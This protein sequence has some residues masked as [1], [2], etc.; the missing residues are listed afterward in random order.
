MSRWAREQNDPAT[1]LDSLLRRATI[2]TTANTFHDSE[3]GRRLL[4]EAQA[5]AHSVGDAAAE[6]RILWNLLLATS[7]SDD[8]PAVGRD[9]GERA[10]AIA[11]AGDHKE[12]TAFILFDLWYAYG[13]LG[14]WNRAI[15]PLLEARELWREL[16]NLPL[17]A[18]THTRLH[19]SALFLGDYE[20]SL[21]YAQEANR[22]SRLSNNLESQAISLSAV[23][24]IYLDRGELQR[25]LNLMREALA[26]GEQA[27]VVTALGGT[28]A[29][30]GWAYGWLGDPARGIALA[31]AAD[32]WIAA[33]IPNVRG[34]ALGP[35]ARLL[36]RTNELER[37]GAIL[38]E[39]GSYRAQMRRLGF[40]V[41]IWVTAGLA[42][43]ELA[44]ARNRP[45]EA[46]AVAE[47]LR[48][49][50]QQRRLRF[51]LPDVVLLQAEALL[52]LGRTEQ[53]G[54]TLRTAERTARELNARRVLWVILD[55]L[56]E[57]EQR[58]G[59]A[60]AEEYR[61]QAWEI[62]QSLAG[63]LDEPE[64]RATFLGRPDVARLAAGRSQLITNKEKQ[65][66]PDR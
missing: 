13:G 4:E 40:V 6:A 27:Q 20:Q 55:R 62:V 56:G 33:H 63:S 25:G 64:L 52:A 48:A 2:R 16:D 21:A 22:L 47:A 66:E 7:L 9:Y 38:D 35:L 31:E 61:D 1:D 29:E 34:W 14:D 46:L 24:H 11:R 41:S 30:L 39:L 3:E 50:L 12:L 26:F 54:R 17:L 15:E 58:R 5:L 57:V 10:L 18:E 53:A 60:A 23:G 19:Y 43:I 44:L 32:E 28:R 8:D 59:N 49:D 65:D 51:L 45:D 37:A 42:Q 36:I